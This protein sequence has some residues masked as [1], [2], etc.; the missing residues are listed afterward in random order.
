MN[1]KARIMT[2]LLLGLFVTSIYFSA[3]TKAVVASDQLE[4]AVDSYVEGKLLYTNTTVTDHLLY[5]PTITVEEV[6][7]ATDVNLE[8]YKIKVA[9]EIIDEEY[10][11][12]GG[13]NQM[14]MTH[15]V[16]KHN[17]T[18]L[19]G[20]ARLF[21]GNATFSVELT[22]LHLDT[23]T[24]WTDLDNTKITFNNGTTYIYG[25]M[26]P[27]D[28]GYLEILGYMLGYAIMNFGLS[29]LWVRTL[30]GINPN[31]NV[32]D[33]INFFD[34]NSATATLG[35]VTE[36]DE[37]TTTGGKSVETIQV[38]F[39][40][41]SLFGWDDYQCDAFYE[42]KTGLLVRIIET[43]GTETF[44]FVPEEVSIKAGLIPFPFVGIIVGFVAIG[45]VAIFAR[46]K[47]K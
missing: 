26:G 19:L 35:D 34:T 28:F 8:F 29:I 12:S 2:I 10:M 5:Y 40:Y 13:F 31:V 38:Y 43:D 27:T 30:I 41:N 45:L 37:I 21:M 46:R 6:I 44:E 47:K 20:A 7:N 25:D 15:L 4:L 16:F 3:S 17:R 39:E 11:G 9:Y 36:I 1:K 22:V 24:E 33:K 42:T 14:E 32:G 23:V 18:T